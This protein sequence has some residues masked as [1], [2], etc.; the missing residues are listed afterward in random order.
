MAKHMNGIYQNDNAIL[1]EQYVRAHVANV[2]NNNS[3]YMCVSMCTNQW[4]ANNI[5]LLVNLSFYVLF[6]FQVNHMKI[7]A[8][9]V[10]AHSFK[11]G[12]T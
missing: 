6:S 7:F 4:T 8:I 2:L 12:V 10:W 5:Y 3:P 9:E 11:Y 1:Y